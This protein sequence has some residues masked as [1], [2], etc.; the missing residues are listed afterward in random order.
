MTLTDLQ[1]RVRR[2]WTNATYSAAFNTSGIPHK[3]YAHAL[4]HMVKATGKLAAIIDDLD[5][6]KEIEDDPGKYVADLVICAAR[7]C[8]ASGLHLESIVELRCAAKLPLPK[9]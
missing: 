3:D 5:H 6:G 9:E 7:F 8:D 1:E 4:L 2:A